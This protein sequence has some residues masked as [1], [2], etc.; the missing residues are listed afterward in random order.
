[1]ELPA[2]QRLG[3]Q[4]KPRRL[5]YPRTISWNMARESPK[6]RAA[7]SPA[8][9]PNNQPCNL[10]TNSGPAGD[11][12]ASRSDRTRKTR[13]ATAP[14]ALAIRKSAGG[15]RGLEPAPARLIADVPGVAASIDVH[16]PEFISI[17]PDEEM[18]KVRLI[19]R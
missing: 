17:G 10:P 4:G 9:G 12:N 19:L 8:K 15:N 5:R 6:V 13:Q 14:A 11:R 7:V 2:K 1:M 18:I 16:T 3:N